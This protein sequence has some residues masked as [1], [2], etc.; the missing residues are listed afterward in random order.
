MENNIKLQLFPN[1]FSICRLRANYDYP[2]WAEND[3]F[4]S[5][6]RTDEE[7]SVITL[8]NK[9]NVCANRNDGWRLIKILGPLDF[10][11]IGVVYSLTEIL[12]KANI[13]VV[14]VSTYDTDYLLVK[15]EKVDEAVE[16]LSEKFG[17][18]GE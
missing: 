15:E 7:L 16:C 10:T 1:R 18:A 17:F 5:I 12:A 6:T 2:R 11:M 14:V 13:S 3:I 4:C 8:E 9:V